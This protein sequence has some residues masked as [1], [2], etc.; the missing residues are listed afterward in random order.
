MPLSNLAFP[1][2]VF[3]SA[4]RTGDGTALLR[5]LD[6]SAVLTDQG[7]EHQ[8][9]MI[10]AWL[11][12][13]PLHRTNQMR[14]INE[15]RRDGQIVLTILTQ[16]PG[17]DGSNA[18]ILHDW[19]FRLRGVRIVSVR[20]EPCLPPQLPLPI[21]TFIHA[22]NNLDLDG[23][24][25]AFADDALVNDQ[26]HDHWG[27]EAIR[28]WAAR[29]VIGMRLAMYVVSVIQHYGHVILTANISGDFDTRGL[30]DPL[31]LTFYFAAPD[32]HIV[33][34]IILQNQPSV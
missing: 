16:E 27:K 8:G 29:D 23:L 17:T 31:M 25:A 7:R 2:R 33:Q 22:V 11:A 12:R 30:P 19:H 3:L 18:Q 15:A 34:L 1:L 26:L 9:D 24:L 13:L 4:V 32:D 14:P 20:I 6:E 28:E 5:A 21:A 10:P